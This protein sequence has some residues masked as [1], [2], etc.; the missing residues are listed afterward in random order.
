M[1][2]IFKFVAQITSQS[3][4]YFFTI[5]KTIVSFG[6]FLI[7]NIRIAATF[8]KKI[9]M[10]FLKSYFATLLAILTTSVIVV[11]LVILII[12]G[13]NKDS[14]VEIADQTIL[15]IELNGELRDQKCQKG[16]LFSKEECLSIPELESILNIAKGDARIKGVYLEI[17]DVQ[18]GIATW[19]RLRSSLEKFKKS[20]KKV[21]S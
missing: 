9:F 17:K 3:Q 12:V 15:H 4:V 10:S 1:S 11:V 14:K 21:I 6:V 5:H 8:D 20:G 13:L 2:K 18:A 16:I 7:A 19:E